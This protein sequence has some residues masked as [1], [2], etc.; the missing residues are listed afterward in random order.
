M[1]WHGHVVRN[2]DNSLARCGGPGLCKHCNHEAKLRKSGALDGDTWL[3]WT[4]REAQSAVLDAYRH[5]VIDHALM[6][7][8]LEQQQKWAWE[9]LNG[10][11]ERKVAALTAK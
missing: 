7:Q 3:R 10:F 6:I 1:I 9:D 5:D 11:W 4:T 8:I 2:D